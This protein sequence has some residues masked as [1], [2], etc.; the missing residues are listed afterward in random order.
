VCRDCGSGLEYRGVLGHNPD[1]GHGHDDHPS[2]G[3]SRGCS[4]EVKENDRGEEIEL[5]EPRHDD[6]GHG[7]SRTAKK[8][9][10]ACEPTRYDVIR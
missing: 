5:R 2:W 3:R 7:Q 8:L 1:L 6:R 10:E 9:K 4:D